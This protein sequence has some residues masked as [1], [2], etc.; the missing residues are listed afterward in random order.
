M[1]RRG[2][3][4]V[5]LQEAVLISVS[6]VLAGVLLTVILR[7]VLLKWTTLNVQIEPQIV[8]ITV[9]MGIV[10]SILGALYPALRAARLDAVDA[11]NYE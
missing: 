3:A 7:F 10:S 8:L 1:P 6:G 11:L 9:V 2:I 4:S 5:I